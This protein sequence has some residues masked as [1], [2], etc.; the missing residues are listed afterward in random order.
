VYVDA[1]Q[2][3]STR[4]LEE[5]KRRIEDRDGDHDGQLQVV[6]MQCSKCVRWPQVKAVGVKLLVCLSGPKV[7]KILA[8]VW[9][10][11]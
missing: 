8:R 2:S 4:H 5:R 1:R 7:A 9:I 11:W 3:A 10:N 6:R